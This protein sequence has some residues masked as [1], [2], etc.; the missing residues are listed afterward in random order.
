M[1]CT[2]YLQIASTIQPLP[3]RWR[4]KR[5]LAAVFSDPDL[6]H[7]AQQPLELCIRII[8]EPESAELNQTY[9]QKSGPTN[10]LSF[11]AE[12]PEH[13]HWHYLGDLAICAPLV[14]KEASQQ[15]KPVLAH[16]AHLTVHG[17]LHLMGYDHIDVEDAAVMEA[18]E[19][20]IL[21]RLKIANPY[22]EC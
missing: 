11:P 9:R 4:F 16:W 22:E 21:Q 5:W 17:V 14:V 8:D 15:Q 6:V 7:Q 1:T 13:V 18:L 20:R 10:V 19:I 2:L 12:I 3:S